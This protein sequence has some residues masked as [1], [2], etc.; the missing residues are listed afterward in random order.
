MYVILNFRV[1]DFAFR[2]RNYYPGEAVV[3]EVADRCYTPNE[4]FHKWMI[5]ALPRLGFLR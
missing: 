4:V 2:K 5:S 3:R 1:L